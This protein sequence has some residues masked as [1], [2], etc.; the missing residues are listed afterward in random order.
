[1]RKQ[2][3]KAALK[4]LIPSSK[5]IPAKVIRTKSGAIKVKIETRH[6]KAVAK[7]AIKRVK[8]TVKRAV[9]KRANP[10]RVWIWVSPT[11]AT[12]IGAPPKG[13]S[14]DDRERVFGSQIGHRVAALTS[15]GW[16]IMTPTA[17]RN[18]GLETKGFP[19]PR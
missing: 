4:K 15:R 14:V 2:T 18:R 7:R 17:A 10:Y 3:T 9:G 5:Y 8:R 19:G 13:R 12:H 11:G 6:L 1:M 16:R